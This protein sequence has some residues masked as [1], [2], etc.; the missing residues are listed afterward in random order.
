MQSFV[1]DEAANATG[2]CAAQ[3]SHGRSAR[4]AVSS[5]YT[6]GRQQPLPQPHAR[7]RKLAIDRPDWSA[8]RAGNA[9]RSAAHAA[10]ARQASRC[11]ARPAECARGRRRR[12][13]SPRR[14]SGLPVSRPAARPTTASNWG[15]AS[16]RSTN[17]CDAATRCCRWCEAGTARRPSA[18][19]RYRSRY[20]ANSAAYS[21]ATRPRNTLAGTSTDCVP[22]E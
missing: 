3:T 13:A 2:C 20:A 6:F 8:K 1:G 10:V 7:Q 11:R 19:G 14:R 18:R 12:C 9:A 16:A 22:S 4:C 5:R 21:G 15:I 17:R